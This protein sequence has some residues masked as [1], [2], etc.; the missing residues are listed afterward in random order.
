MSVSVEPRPSAFFLY[1][2]TAA[3]LLSVGLNVF[4]LF[5]DARLPVP[6][7]D[8]AD[9]QELVETEAELRMTQRLLARCQH[10]HQRKDSLLVIHSLSSTE[11]PVRR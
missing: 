9:S 11:P 7:T 8:P 1:L 2:L 5:R 10:D 6:A 3:L 4:L